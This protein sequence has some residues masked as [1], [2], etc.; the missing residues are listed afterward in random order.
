MKH[1]DRGCAIAVAIAMLW[2]TP[3]ASA[4]SAE[5]ETLFREG[6]TLIKQGKIAAG[7]DKLDASARLESSTGTWLNLGDCR[8][9]LGKLASAWAAFR[10]AEDVARRAGNDD[11]RRSE[12][13]RR[14][15]LI[16]AKMPMLVIEIPQ[17]L[18][19]LVVRRDGSVVDPAMW[20]S[21]VPIDPGRYTITAEAPGYA[22]WR[23]DVSVDGVTRRRVVTVPPLQRAPV[24]AKPHT[25]T[26]IQDL[27]GGP[28]GPRDPVPLATVDP[29]V[30]PMHS[31]TSTPMR[32]GSEPITMHRGRWTT[33]RYVA[34]GIAIA[35]VAALGGGVM[36]GL[37][38]RDLHSR[39][40][41]RCPTIE[42]GD[43][44]GLRLDA[45]AA[46]SATRA[47]VFYAL[48]GGAAVAATILWFLGAPDD[49]PIAPAVGNGQVGVSFTRSF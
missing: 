16:E 23:A 28:S 44:E 9:K 17:R 39:A 1:V 36:Y 13:A 21:P 14:A 15:S 48:G 41:E 35:G 26:P 37:R 38:S 31:T 30:A 34:A 4:Q 12:A 46:E 24:T 10:K 29:P 8:E 3:L 2:C 6:R 19:G 7:C 27:T 45:Q 20:S 40:D 47:N 49:A 5:A 22:T 25:S 11:K 33:Q 18:D 32:E 43:P 42:C